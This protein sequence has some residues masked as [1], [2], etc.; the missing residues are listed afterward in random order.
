MKNKHPRLM[1]STFIF[2]MG[3]R[4]T[5]FIIEEKQIQKDGK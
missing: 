1:L 4:N 3:S 2:I 5:L